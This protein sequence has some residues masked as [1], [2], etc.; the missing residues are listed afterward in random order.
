MF[1]VG[2]LLHDETLIDIIH[3]D[4]YVILCGVNDSSQSSLLELDK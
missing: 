1:V 2:F 4:S 3:R